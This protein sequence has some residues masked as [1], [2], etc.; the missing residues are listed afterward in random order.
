M[1]PLVSITSGLLSGFFNL[2][3]KIVVKI[4]TIIPINKAGKGCGL[5]W[6]V[7]AYAIPPYQY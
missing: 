4:P 5:N 3:L 7:A 1:V 2:W 6:E